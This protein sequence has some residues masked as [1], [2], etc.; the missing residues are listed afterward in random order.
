MESYEIRFTGFLPAK[1]GKRL[2]RIQK[3]FR[4]RAKDQTHAVDRIARSVPG[5]KRMVFRTFAF[6]FDGRIK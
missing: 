5:Y 2:R 3:R 6:E 4:I 1:R